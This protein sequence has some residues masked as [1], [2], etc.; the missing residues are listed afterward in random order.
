[1]TTL[2][3]YLKI[4]PRKKEMDL[5]KPYKIHHQLGGGGGGVFV[6][7][8]SDEA[9]K[10]K[11]S[12]DCPSTALAYRNRRTQ[13]VVQGEDRRKGKKEIT[14]KSHSRGAYDH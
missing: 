6:K 10:K 12:K 11:F 1:M 5:L 3:D 13:T 2:S 8:S 14:V 4:T 9:K 7:S